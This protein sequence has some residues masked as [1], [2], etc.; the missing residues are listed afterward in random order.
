MLM[1]TQRRG[2]VILAV[3]AVLALIVAG[4]SAPYLYSPP[5][6]M[7]FGEQRTA[8]AESLW[9]IR[10]HAAC[11]ILALL[12]GPLQFVHLVRKRRPAVHR[13]LGRCYLVAVAAGA[14]GAIGL[15]PTAFGGAVSTAGFAALAVVWVGCGSM[16][17]ARIRARD[18][19]GHRRWMLRTYA[20]TFAAVTLRIELPI[21]I[22]IGL[23][24][25]YAYRAVA[26]LAWVPNL[27][28]VELWLRRA[29]TA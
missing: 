20:L 10:L 15:A 22:A 11:G 13:W 27:I 28:V 12:I 18:I 16:A 1:T 25:E 29:R 6:E 24:F 4:L 14:V 5:A 2:R 9:A 7:R 17:Y 23:D 8:F 21:L 26:W 3:T 19:E